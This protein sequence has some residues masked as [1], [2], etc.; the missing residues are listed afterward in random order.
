MV[1]KY[2]INTEN[3]CPI[4]I[5]FAKPYSLGLML[6]TQFLAMACVHLEQS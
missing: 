1:S 2:I 6:C 4:F 3:F 5:E